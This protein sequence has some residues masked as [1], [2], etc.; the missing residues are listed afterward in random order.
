MV[1]AACLR[2]QSLLQYT[3]SGCAT[4]E[5]P[6]PM[7]L[8]APGA[9][10]TCR[11]RQVI[12]DI[13]CADTS[14]Q[15]SLTALLVVTGIKTPAII[16]VWV[17]F[18]R[19]SHH[20]TLAGKK[21]AMQT[22]PALN[23]R[24][25][26]AS[27]SQVVGSKACTTAVWPHYIFNKLTHSKPKAGPSQVI[28]W[29]GVCLQSNAVSTRVCSWTESTVLSV[30]SDGVAVVCARECSALFVSLL[31]KCSPLGVLGCCW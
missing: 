28:L 17:V 3:E 6:G 11:M 27:A 12:S 4:L 19:G 20:V 24:D 15:C 9:S 2:M 1:A 7:H 23:S 22:R 29:A 30:T 13:M 10:M 18:E 16:F 31:H 8:A 14:G 21:L 5:H 25:L 26:P